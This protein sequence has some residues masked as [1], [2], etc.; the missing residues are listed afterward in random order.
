MSDIDF[1]SLPNKKYY[2]ISEVSTL[3]GIKQ[4]EIRYW[5]KFQPKLRS[6]SITRRYD[7]KKI[8]LLLEMKKLIKD[9]GIKPEKIDAHLNAKKNPKP[10]Q[11]EIKKE[12]IKIKDIIKKSSKVQIN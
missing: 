1:S 7:L 10:Q 12:L 3:L 6:K 11:I 5:E 8:K 4:T 9:Q 2:S